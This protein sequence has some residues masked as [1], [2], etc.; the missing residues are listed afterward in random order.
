MR[1]LLISLFLLIPFLC[2]AQE[3]VRTFKDTRII[4]T[5]STETLKKG[6]MDIRIGHRFGDIGGD[7]GGWS[8]FYGLENASDVL[9]GAEYG[10]TNNLMV[11]LFRTKGSGPLKQLVNLTGKYK[12]L[13]QNSESNTPISMALSFTGTVSTMKS[14][15]T[16]GAINNF[17]QF[18]HR[19]SY[20]GQLL[21][22]SKFSDGFSLQ[23][24]PS[25]THRNI[26]DIEDENGLFA[27]GAAC[28][29]QLSKVLGL[30]I[31]TTIPFSELR[32]SDNDYHVPLGIGFEIDTGGHIFQVNF[33]NSTGMMETDYIPYTRSNWSDGEFRLGFTISRLFNL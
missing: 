3:A 9:I 30:I 32:T 31:D 18:A 33:T 20:N 6:Y 1:L 10:F 26:V 24:S 5:Q 15:D 28:R 17:E 7:N 25:Y 29:I 21:I 4:N 11:G 27:L 22:S 13:S 19:L 12:L 16:Q 8:T 2:I 14:S 23:V